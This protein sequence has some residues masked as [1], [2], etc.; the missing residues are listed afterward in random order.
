MSEIGLDPTT[1]VSVILLGEETWSHVARFIEA[2]LKTK[3]IYLDRPEL[4]VRAN[5]RGLAL[6]M[7]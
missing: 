3:K 2:L 7:C 6:I 5:E 4:S 1:I